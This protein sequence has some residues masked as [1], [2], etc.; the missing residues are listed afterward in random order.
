[1]DLLLYVVIISTILY[2]LVT[3]IAYL[4]SFILYKGICFKLTVPIVKSGSFIL[5]VYTSIIADI[6]LYHHSELFSLVIKNS[7]IFILLV[8]SL[9]YAKFGKGHHL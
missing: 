7:V 4:A 9:L 1:M 5:F 6:W 2:S 3:Y 8:V